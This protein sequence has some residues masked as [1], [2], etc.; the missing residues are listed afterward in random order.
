MQ[1]HSSSVNEVVNYFSSDLNNG[2]TEKEVSDRQSKY[3]LNVLDKKK[4]R[5][6][7]RKFLSQFN[8][9]MIIILI[10]S[11]VI[12]FVLAIDSGDKNEYILTVGYLLAR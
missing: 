5:S 12:S 10:I 2:I 3:G 4:D 6:L 8:N 1:F 9:A 11:A 7:V